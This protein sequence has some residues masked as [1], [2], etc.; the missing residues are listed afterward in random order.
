[1]KS[2]TGDKLITAANGAGR[3]LAFFNFS[4]AMIVATILFL[5]SMYFIFRP[6]EFSKDTKGK[7]L[8]AT[9]SKGED[10]KWMCDLV[11]TYTVDGKSFNGNKNVNTNE[12]YRI[13]EHIPVSYNPQDPGKHD[14]NVVGTFWAG[15]FLLILSILIPGIYGIIWL[16]TRSARGAGTAFLGFSLI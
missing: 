16:F 6:K 13:G 2:K 10:D 7:I 15:L 11:Y 4:I 12:K 14:I 8:N 5:L 1:M 9:C 3:W